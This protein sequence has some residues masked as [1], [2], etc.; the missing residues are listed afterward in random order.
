MKRVR[1]KISRQYNIR[2]QQPKV[3]IFYVSRLYLTM[4]AVLHVLLVL[5]LLGTGAVATIK[6]FPKANARRELEHYQIEM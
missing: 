5:F 4:N 3:L 1:K 2:G 6:V